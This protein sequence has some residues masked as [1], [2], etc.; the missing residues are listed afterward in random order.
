MVLTL[1][2][3]N[4]RTMLQAGKMAE[5]AEEVLKYGMD[6]VA[7]REVRW[8]GHGRVDRKKYS[9]LY[10]EP[11]TRTGQCSTGF[12]ISFKIMQSYLGFEP[13]ID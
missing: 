6:M 3:W 4:V 7:L 5:V 2:T 9:M 13:Q 11:E 10:S 8:S 12:I 1:A